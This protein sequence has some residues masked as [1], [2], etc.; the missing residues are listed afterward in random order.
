MTAKREAAMP[1]QRQQQQQQS[2]P[3]EFDDLR[4]LTERKELE[5]Q[6]VLAATEQR[7]QRSLDEKQGEVVAVV[8]YGC[9]C[10]LM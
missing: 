10:C 2:L 8:C 5:L 9:A 6:A 4:R 3:L 1:A 7:W